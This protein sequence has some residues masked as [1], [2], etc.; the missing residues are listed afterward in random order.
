MKM[1]YLLYIFVPF[2]LAFS[3]EQNEDKLISDT[4]D[5]IM[6]EWIWVKS[7]YYNT[8]SGLPFV[9]TPDSVGYSVRQLF[10]TDGTYL[11]FKND[12]IESSGIFWLE[13]VDNQDEA[14]PEFR[15]FSQKEEYINFTRIFISGDTLL[16]DNTAADGTTRLF[17]RSGKKN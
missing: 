2:I 17:H 10:S 1:K 5:Q 16:F 15:L 6:G 11:Q 13:M 4:E 3:C 7:T 14:E 12:L 8:N 9:L